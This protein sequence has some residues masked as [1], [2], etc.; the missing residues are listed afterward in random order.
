LPLNRRRITRKQDT[1]IYTFCSCDR[2]LDP[3]T[4]IYEL[5]LAILKMYLHTKDE[6]LRWK[7]SKVIA[8]DK[9]HTDT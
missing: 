1:Q 5:D 2:N 6:L 4:F 8:L 3:M 7:L 9:R